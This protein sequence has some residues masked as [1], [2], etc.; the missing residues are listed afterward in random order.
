MLYCDNALLTQSTLILFC[1]RHCHPI[2]S[3]AR[4]LIETSLSNV[5]Q[6]FFVLVRNKNGQYSKSCNCLSIKEDKW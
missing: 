5:T 1:P 2:S 4:F 6:A 3:K